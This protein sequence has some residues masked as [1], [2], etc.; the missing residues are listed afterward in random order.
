[1]VGNAEW[2]TFHKVRS[3]L[4][5]SP[6]DNKIDRQSIHPRY[7]ALEKFIK[8]ISDDTSF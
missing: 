5:F 7:Q 1:M 4:L 2:G 6:Y 8:N 3:V